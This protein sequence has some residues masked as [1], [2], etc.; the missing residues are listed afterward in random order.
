M[1]ELYHDREGLQHTPLRVEMGQRLWWQIVLLDV[2][3]AEDISSQ[4]IF[5]NLPNSPERIFFQDGTSFGLPPF[6][7]GYH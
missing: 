1:L 7:S 2:R 6:N 5:V 3:A 4:H